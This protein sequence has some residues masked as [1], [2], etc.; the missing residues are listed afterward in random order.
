M[1]VQIWV[2]VGLMLIFGVMWVITTVA[3]VA[4][5]SAYRREGSEVFQNRL[6]GYRSAQ[7]DLSEILGDGQSCLTATQ[8]IDKLDAHFVSRYTTAGKP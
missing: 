8:I 3:W 2:L 6:R 5:R 1:T 7:A 4:E